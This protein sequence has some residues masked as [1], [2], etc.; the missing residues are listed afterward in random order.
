MNNIKNYSSISIVLIAISAAVALL[1][2]LGASQDALLSL[3][4]SNP[5]NRGLQDILGGQV[6]R[7]VT[8]IF[9]HFGLMH[10]VFNLLWIW[11]LGK[12]IEFRKGPTFYIGFVLVVGAV[13]NLAQYLLNGSPYFGG[14]SGVVYGLFGYIWMRGRADP[15]FAS[16][17]NKTTVIMML[18]WFVLCWTGLLGPIANWAHTMGLLAGAAWGLIASQSSD[19]L[20]TGRTTVMP[21]QQRLEYLSTADML[22][23]E[24]Q[25]SWVREQYPSGARAKYDSVAGKLDIIATVLNLTLDKAIGPKQHQSLEVAF[26]DALVQET[27]VQWAMLDDGRVRTPVLMIAATPVVVVPLATLS[28]GLPSTD[29]IDV[30]QLFRSAVEA[31]RRQQQ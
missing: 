11:D 25:R 29:V 26:A 27:G 21:Q 6:W 12:L 30:H 2:N 7:L 31:I 28:K 5:D 3:Y 10:L 23:I 16:G 8:P 15:G 17:L 18:A 22:Q 1:S 9:I 14:M 24:G 4:I 20:A 19:G 13:S